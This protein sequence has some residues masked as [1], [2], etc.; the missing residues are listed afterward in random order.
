MS[1]AK[2]NWKKFWLNVWETLKGSFILVTF[3]GILSGIAFIGTIN[4]DWCG[5]IS[6]GFNGKRIAFLVVVVVLLGAYAG[7]MAYGFG[8]KGYQMLVSGNMKRLSAEQLGTQ[9]KISS[10]KEE[11]E[12]RE[13]KGFAIGGVIAFF[14]ILF[15]ILAGVNGDGINAAFRALAT[16]S[17][18][19]APFE[20]KGVAILM[21]I[22]MLCCGWS[23]LPFAYLNVSGI[24][25]SY[26]WSCL[27]GLIPIL[28]TGI[29]YIVGA[30]GA[31]AK[32]VR[33][34][35]N[36]DRAAAEEANKPKKVNYGGLPGTKPKKRK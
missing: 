24:A 19:V 28:V 3:F 33:A 16:E 20:D 7:A 26:Y 13:W 10:H 17:G 2:E 29:F 12:Y 35:E 34:Q 15:G 18:E 22:S 36:A 23:L 5:P 31:R 8:G 21:L 1:R 14:T 11:Q 6:E 9:M 30:Y 25:I 4:A 32:S 27:F